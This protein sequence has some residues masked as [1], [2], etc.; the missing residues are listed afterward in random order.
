MDLLDSLFIILINV[1]GLAQLP[2][3]V[4]FI[5]GEHA[6]KKE[7]FASQVDKDNSRELLDSFVILANDDGFLKQMG[8]NGIDQ[9]LQ[10]LKVP[11]FGDSR[12]KIEIL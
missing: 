8:D 7:L 3:D 9:L 10:I 6:P 12:E 11:P 4:S 5:F 1:Q 2:D